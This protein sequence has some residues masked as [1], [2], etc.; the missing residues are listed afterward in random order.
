ML[1]PMGASPTVTP[2]G[3]QSQCYT[4]WEPVPLLHPVGASL[5]VTPCGSQ[6]QSSTH[7]SGWCICLCKNQGE[8]QKTVCQ[9]QRCT[10][11]IGGSNGVLGTYS[12]SRSKF[13]HF[14]V[15]FS[16]YFVKKSRREGLGL[17]RMLAQT[18]LLRGCYVT[19]FSQL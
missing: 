12:S 4:L 16:K 11:L 9:S 1:H 7:S 13:F 19:S 14:H 10:Q 17:H 5:N 18:M 6:S 15:V 8:S 2:C 3:S